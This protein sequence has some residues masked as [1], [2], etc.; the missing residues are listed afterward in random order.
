M[1]IDTTIK[2]ICPSCNMEMEETGDLF[3]G[4]SVQVRCTNPDCEKP[5]L[6]YV[7]KG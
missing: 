4:F 3:P 5:S 6:V 2:I 1:N 7:K